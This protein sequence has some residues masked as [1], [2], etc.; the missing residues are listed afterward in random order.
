NPYVGEKPYIVHL[1]RLVPVK[2]HD[3]LL[4]AFALSKIDAKLI[5]IGEGESREFIE[6]KVLSLGLN[7][8]VVFAGMQ[9]NPYAIMKDARLLVLSSD[10]EGLSMA[11]L[12]ALALGVPVVSTDC[13]SGPGEILR[14]YLENALVPVGET[15]QLA[16][17]IKK[18]YETPANIATDIL[19]RFD[20][21]Q[22]IGQYIDL[23]K[24]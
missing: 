5:L 18:Q 9:R 12:E 22:V 2:R 1:G 16:A 11:I 19:K 6:E 4:E 3:R 7:E 21:D 14:G 10:Y 17:M 20:G 23:M 15:Q 13:P 8:K 24:S